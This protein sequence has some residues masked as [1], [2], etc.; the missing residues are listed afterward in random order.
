M[1]DSPELKTIEKCT[2][3]L[4]TALSGLERSFVHFLAQEGFISNDVS[5]MVLE[6]RSVLTEEEKA[7]ELVKAI[8]RRVKLDANSYHTL[9]NRFKEDGNL[10]RP[11][12]TKLEREYSELIGGQGDQNV[13]C[14]SET[15]Q[16][17]KYP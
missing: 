2:P 16:H 8:K 12:V 9:L 15:Q 10:Y 1:S 4:E 6:P 13:A 11:I 3:E 14:G 17:G 5:G 7:G